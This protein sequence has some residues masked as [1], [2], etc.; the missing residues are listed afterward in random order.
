MYKQNRNKNFEEI[1][2]INRRGNLINK[3]NQKSK[4]PE[5]TFRVT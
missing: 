3:V 4:K 2:K 1:H 5:E